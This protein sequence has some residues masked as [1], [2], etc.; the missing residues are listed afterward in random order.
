MIASMLNQVAT[1]WEKTGQTDRYGKPALTAP[2]QLPCRWED[3]QTQIM[4]KQGAEVISKSRVY[5][6]TTISLDGYLALGTFA[7]AD[8]RPLDNAYEVQQVSTTPDLRA[9]E[10]LTTVYL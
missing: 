3:R 6:S 9:L 10:T 5:C 1:Y 2:V 8:P 4:N 7:D